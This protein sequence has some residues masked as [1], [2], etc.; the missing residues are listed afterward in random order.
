MRQW[1]RPLFVITFFGLLAALMLHTLLAN[2]STHAAGYD[3]FHFHWNFW[4]IQTALTDLDLNIYQSNY[5][6]TPYTNNLAYHTLATFWY[7]LWQ[8]LAPLVGMTAAVNLIIWLNA[9]LNGAIMA[10]W[11]RAN[12][13]SW[14]V[15][16]IGGVGLMALPTLRYFYYN[17]HLNLAAW[18]WLPA[19][20]WL[21]KRVSDT[22]QTGQQRR[23]V[24]LALCFGLMMWAVLLTD[25]QLPLY[26]ALLLIFYIPFTLL[27]SSQRRQMLLAGGLA[28]LVAIGL[29]WFAGPLPYLLDWEGSLPAT[30]VDG[31]PGI[32]LVGFFRVLDGW[33]QWDTPSVGIFPLLVVWAG[34]VARKTTPGHQAS[35]MWLL[36]MILPL[37]LSLGP[38]F[39]LGDMAI[40]LA[41]YRIAFDL[42]DSNLLMPWR[43]APVF[44]IAAITFAAT[45]IGTRYRWWFSALG[46]VV[47]LATLRAFWTAPIQPVLPN[48][49][50]YEAIGSEPRADYVVLEVPTALGT[51]Q[52]IVGDA[53]A[54]AYQRYAIQHRRRVLNGFVARAPLEHFWYVRTDDAL[55]SWL[56]QRRDLDDG[57][58][59]ARLREIVF[60]WPVGYVV[61]HQAAIGPE[62][63]ANQEIIG[64]FNRQFDLL[65]P[66]WV[67]RDAV[68]WRTASQRIGCPPRTPPP[69][70]DG[71]YQ[72]DIGAAEDVRYIQDGWYWAEQLP[73]IDARWIGPAPEA[74]IIVDLPPA[75]YTLRVIGQ[76]FDQPRSVTLLLNGEAIGEGTFS[77]DGLST[78]ST[79]IPA[80][81]IGSGH[82][83]RVRIVADSAVP[84]DG[85]RTLAVL[86]ESVTFIAGD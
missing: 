1:Q 49:D 22:I 67:E 13:A 58:A 10:G 85:D 66:V 19:L 25:S 12:R 73:G 46:V 42:S 27:H 54:L 70:P 77:P 8:L 59:R 6:L 24:I 47:A 44:V 14:G 45:T 3:Y 74:G 21:W 83:L 4:W 36:A 69:S 40:N 53:H 68:V 7:P 57:S 80:D 61:V 79:R 60:D 33:W 37:L 82:A 29:S 86:V 34:L 17:T 35:T 26:A 11:L 72:I 62:R 20:L 15:A 65:C 43:F 50:F 81:L 28:L 39:T 41:P 76:S 75:A 56:G 64:F 30:V 18:F 32:P 48:Y 84:A 38:T 9:T 23:S 16:L 51:G 31:R 2:I 63:A 55:L 78:I 52:I 71:T 5:V